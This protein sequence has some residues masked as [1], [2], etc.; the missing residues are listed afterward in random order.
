M[1][2]PM[3]MDVVVEVTMIVLTVAYLLECVIVFDFSHSHKRIPSRIP[4]YESV[5]ISRKLID[6][7]D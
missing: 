1:D 4:F 5:K 2:R 3:P 6:I 7:I